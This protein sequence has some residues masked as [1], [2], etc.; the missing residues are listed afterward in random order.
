MDKKIINFGDT[1][2]QKYK[3][4]QHKS[5]ILINNIDVNKIVVF[6]KV[7]FDKKGLKYYIG[8][9]DGEKV[10][11]LCILLPKMSACRRDFD[12]TKYMSFLIKTDELLEKYNEIQ[13]KF[14]NSIKKKFENY[15]ISKSQK[16]RKS[17][18]D[19]PKVSKFL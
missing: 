16:K 14:S 8:Y 12:E 17:E 6:N 18:K 2:I 13:E 3:F 4:H 15:Q 1:D 7:S 11:P 19:P 10:E 5:P 9:K